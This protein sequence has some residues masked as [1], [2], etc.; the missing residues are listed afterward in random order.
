MIVTVSRLD[1]Y[2]GNHEDSVAAVQI[3]EI[4]LKS[5]Q[6]IA[7]G[8]LGFDPEGRWDEASRPAAVTLSILRIAT[9]MLMESGG[10]I[11][12]TGKSFQDSSRTFVSYSNYRKYL[13][14]LDPY[15][16]TRF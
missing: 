8:Y 10:N 2:S 16:D 13:Q 1:D 12:L 4:F 3:K 14:P 7:E 9:L 6:E 15:R 5:A 11:G